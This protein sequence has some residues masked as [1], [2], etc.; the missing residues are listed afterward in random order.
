MPV[1][2]ELGLIFVHVPKTA[3]SSIRAV[4]RPYRQAQSTSLLRRFSSHLPAAEP[5]DRVHIRL[6]DRAA[7]IRRKIGAEVFDGF[8]SFTVVRD[9]Y[10][11]AI[12]EYE[13]LRQRPKHRRH[14]AAASKTFAEF[15]KSE[16]ERRS[17]QI[18]MIADRAGRIL[19]NDIV[20]FENLAEGVNAIFARVGVTGRI[21]S[22]RRNTSIRRPREDYLTDEAVSIINCRS[23]RDF[24]AFG[25]AMIGT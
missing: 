3:G 25:Y 21:G 22:E 18:S 16:P 24:D 14:A 15:L 19:V 5:L 2:P 10:D 6:H 17:L 9:P 7:W 11:R 20:R 1:F 23:R 4:L 8:L 13:F 12:S